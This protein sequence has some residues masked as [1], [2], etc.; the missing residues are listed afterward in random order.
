MRLFSDVVRCLFLVLAWLMRY[1]GVD[2]LEVEGFFTCNLAPP[3][4]NHDDP[5]QF[6]YHS[7]SR[8][9]SLITPQ[10]LTP[11]LVA[12]LAPC[13]CGAGALI[14]S[15]LIDKDLLGKGKLFHQFAQHDKRS[16]Q[17]RLARY[18]AT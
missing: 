13:N 2:G 14:E 10:A 18:L 11:L 16:G 5:C 1:G 12:G 3:D 7:R 17:Q 4:Q 6:T 9:Q 8:V 15:Y